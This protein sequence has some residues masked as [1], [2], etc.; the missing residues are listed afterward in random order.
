MIGKGWVCMVESGAG[1]V[2]AEWAGEK[3]GLSGWE[4]WMGKKSKQGET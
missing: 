2:E 4:K 3:A 1:W